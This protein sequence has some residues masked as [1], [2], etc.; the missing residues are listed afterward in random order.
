MP[1]QGDQAPLVRPT[2]SFARTLSPFFGA[3]TFGAHP[4][5]LLRASNAA[6]AR[7]SAL[8]GGFSDEELFTRARRADDSTAGAT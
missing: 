1:E 3:L 7:C 2:P 4:R 5:R 6:G 8:L